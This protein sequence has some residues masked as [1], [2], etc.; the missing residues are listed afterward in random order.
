MVNYSKVGSW[1]WGGGGGEGGGGRGEVQTFH[2][3]CYMSLVKP[4]PWQ[5]EV[6]K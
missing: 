6:E 1:E 4:L 3:P 2:A 5:P